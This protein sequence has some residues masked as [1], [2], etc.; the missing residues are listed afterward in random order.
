MGGSQSVLFSTLISFIAGWKL[1]WLLKDSILLCFLGTKLRSNGNMRGLSYTCI[2][3]GNMLQRSSF[4]GIVN[5][6]PYCT[7][8]V[9]QLSIPRL[10]I[11]EINS[12]PSARCYASKNLYL[13][14][15]CY[16]L[17]LLFLI[18]GNV[19]SLPLL[20]ESLHINIHWRSTNWRFLISFFRGFHLDHTSVT[21]QLNYKQK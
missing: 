6:F 13:V 5:Q 3:R 9:T 15:S 1:L 17:Y 10:F 16:K 12:S 21:N 11:P 19:F 7:A 8:T 20:V 2:R 4:P 14:Y 18:K